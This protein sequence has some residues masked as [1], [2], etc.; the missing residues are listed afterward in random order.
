MFITLTVLLILTIFV[1]MLVTTE[2]TRTFVEALVFFSVSHVLWHFVLV[3]QFSRHIINNAAFYNLY[4]VFI[5]VHF[6]R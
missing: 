6:S 3:C 4:N 5:I 2:K 1:A